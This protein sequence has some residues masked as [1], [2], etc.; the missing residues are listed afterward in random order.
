LSYNNTN[1]PFIDTFFGRENNSQSPFIVNVSIVAN[2]FASM[3]ALLKSIKFCC[4]FLVDKFT[5]DWEP[6][7]GVVV[8][9]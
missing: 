5:V 9:V 1:N 7:I 3:L 2:V 8:L 6:K 4:G